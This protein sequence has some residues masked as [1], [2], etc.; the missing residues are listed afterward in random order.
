MTRKEVR[1]GLERLL[2]PAPDGSAETVLMRDV[3]KRDLHVA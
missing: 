1:E 2:K 3:P